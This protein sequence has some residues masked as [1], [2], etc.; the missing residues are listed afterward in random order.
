MGPE[1]AW[2]R[3]WPTYVKTDWVQLSYT[4]LI[5]FPYKISAPDANDFVLSINEN[6]KDG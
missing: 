6:G 4:L 5:S 3:V 1:D 2:Y